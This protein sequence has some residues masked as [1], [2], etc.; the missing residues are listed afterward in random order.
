MLERLNIQP[1]TVS[2]HISKLEAK[3][4]VER[5][6]SDEDRRL[7]VL[8]LTE[9]GKKSAE[10]RLAKSKKTGQ[11]ISFI[12]DEKEQD[13]LLRLLDKLHEGLTQPLKSDEKDTDDVRKR[14]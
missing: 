9:S 7:V 10:N 13:D 5:S 6:R 3:G 1:A 4:L 8:S 12:L 11:G 2:E 14:S